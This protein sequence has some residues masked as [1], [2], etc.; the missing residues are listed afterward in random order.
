MMSKINNCNGNN[1]KNDSLKSPLLSMRNK[2]G[3]FDKQKTL[4]IIKL[5]TTKSK[6]PTK[7][8]TSSSS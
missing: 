5:L 7:K 3:K 1:T 8:E 4:D 2:D 6:R